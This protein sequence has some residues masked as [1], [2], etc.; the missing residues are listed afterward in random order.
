MEA[1]GRRSMKTTSTNLAK[2]YHSEEEF[3]VSGEE[4]SNR[5]ISIVSRW[6]GYMIFFGA[7]MALAGFILHL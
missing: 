7:V 6:S 1:E 3:F 4:L 2:E 5:W